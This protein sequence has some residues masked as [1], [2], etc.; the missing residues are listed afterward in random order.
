MN[1]N[2]I[3]TIRPIGVVVHFF[4]MQSGCRHKCKRTGKIIKDKGAT[5]AIRAASNLP[6]RQMLQLAFLL[7]LR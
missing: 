1:R 3:P 5:E 6:L 2:P 7:R 4:G